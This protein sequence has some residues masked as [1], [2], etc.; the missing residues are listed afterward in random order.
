MLWPYILI[1][2]MTRIFPLAVLLLGVLTP[3]AFPQSEEDMKSLRR[4]IDAVRDSQKLIL[5]ELD[6]IKKLNEMQ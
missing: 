3:A 4:D 1:M 2:R 5:T 6:A